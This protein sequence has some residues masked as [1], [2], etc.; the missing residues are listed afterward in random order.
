MANN[1]IIF[2]YILFGIGL[3]IIL[4][5]G[6]SYCST[7]NFVCSDGAHAIHTIILHGEQNT[8]LW[9]EERTCNPSVN[10]HDRSNQVITLFDNS[11]YNLRITLACVQEKSDGYLFNQ[12]PSAFESDCTDSR[13]LG[14][15]I[16]FNDD[17][18]FDERTEQVIPNNWHKD[19]PRITDA[20][21]NINIPQ[22]DNRYY[23]SGQHRMRIVLAQDQANRKPCQNSGFGEA[24]DYTVQI[25]QKPSY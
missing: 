10:Y 7:G 6:T 20:D 21:L 16:D 13:Y 12:D 5:Y 3:F 14:I 8:R 17:G 9:D 25:L 15:W 1:V 19:D 11:A 4:G 24:R 2:I 23:L 18:S 22:I